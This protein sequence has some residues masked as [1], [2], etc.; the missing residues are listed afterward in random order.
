MEEFEKTLDDINAKLDHVVSN[1]DTGKMIFHVS[2][3]ADEARKKALL[4][5]NIVGKHGVLIQKHEKDI[6]KLEKSDQRIFQKL[7]NLKD[8]ISKVFNTQKVEFT[9]FKEAF[10][11]RIDTF[12]GN[13]NERLFKYIKIAI[14]V[15]VTGLL[16]F[17]GAIGGLYFFTFTLYKESNSQYQKSNENLIKSLELKLNTDK[18]STKWIHHR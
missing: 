7:D 14:Y 11:S 15:I 6:E 18:D 1:N 5:D 2:C 17:G 10:E 16:L 3:A 9:K 13:I 8:T 4:L 12:T